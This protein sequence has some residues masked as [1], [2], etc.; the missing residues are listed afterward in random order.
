MEH[1]LEAELT[2]SGAPPHPAAVGPLVERCAE[3]AIKRTIGSRGEARL[4]EWKLEQDRL[5]LVLE[6]SSVRPHQALLA[7]VKRLSEELGR[8]EKVGVRSFRATSY[9]VRLVLDPPPKTAIT[10]PIPNKLV[11]DGAEATLELVDLPEEGL[12]DNWMHRAAARL[13]EKA[14][15]QSKEGQQQSGTLLY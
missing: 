1:R 13:Q 5:T 2:L 11:I 6:A 8:T 14:R 3:E 10:L 9:R 7:L 15:R 12:R 4:T